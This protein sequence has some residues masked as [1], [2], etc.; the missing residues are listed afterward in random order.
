MIIGLFLII[1]CGPD[2]KVSKLEVRGSEYFRDAQIKKI[3]LTKTAGLFRRGIFKQEIFDGDL[4]AIRSLYNNSGFLDAAVEG[5]L[6]F[7]TI[8][9][10]VSIDVVIKEG[11][12]TFVG[13]IAFSGNTV[14]PGD[15]LGNRLIMKKGEPADPRKTDMDNY[16]ITSIYDDA[17]YADVKVQSDFIANDFR[18]RITHN[19]TEGEK[20]YVEDVEITGL[21]RTRKSVVMK[22]I[23]LKPGDLF[24]YANLLKSQRNLYNLGVFSSIRTQV[25]NGTRAN[26]KTAQFMVSEKRPLTVNL[27]VGYGTRDY[28]RLGAGFTHVN[29]LGRAWQGK[30]E[31]KISF[32]EYSLNSQLN[33]PKF[34]ISPVKYGIGVFYQM[35][36]EIGFRTRRIGLYNEAR[37]DMLG[38]QFLFKHDVENVRTYFTA[39]NG[40]PDSVRNDWLNGLT[41]NWIRDNRDDPFATSRGSYVNVTLETSG[42]IMPANADYLRPTVEIRLF[43]PLASFIAASSFKIAAVQP[44]APSAGVPVYKR[45]YCGGT[46]SV[47]GYSEW[48]IGPKDQY[49]NPLGG[50]ALFE[51]SGEI[52]FPIYRILGGVIFIDG[53]NIWQEY[54]D[55]AVSTELRWGT[56]GGLRLKTP[57]GSV[58]FDYGLK[59][60]RRPGESAG[61][62]HFAVGEAF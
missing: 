62:L 5:G 14:F 59:L 18:A 27:W 23:D 15:S 44:F 16:I 21:D 32:A 4:A 35:K 3:M 2:F 50:I 11:S 1:L 6:V 30:I 57:L 31:G 33:F 54:G 9:K 46:T 39:Q 55:I 52:R 10:T 47:R 7:D 61:A 60:G 20:Q 22:E 51:T 38:G 34:L 58:R 25:K 12:Q 43:K 24:R 41:M 13:E 29:V 53:G 17:G 36:D 28:L 19:I 37:L 56:G 8:A 45:F 48:S 49:G 26:L 40:P 42:I